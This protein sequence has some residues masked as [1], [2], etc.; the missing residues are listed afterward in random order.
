[1][2][3][4][5]LSTDQSL[6]TES[7]MCD[8]RLTALWLCTSGKKSLSTSS[9]RAFRCGWDSASVGHRPCFQS[10]SS[11][12]TASER[13]NR[14]TL[15]ISGTSFES[16]VI[17]NKYIGS[18]DEI[19]TYPA[20]SNV[21]DTIK[22]IILTSFADASFEIMT[23]V[24]DTAV[25][26]ADVVMA[27]EQTYWDAAEILA[28]KLGAEIFCT[29]TGQFRVQKRPRF[30]DTVPVA[31][32]DEGP[33]GVLVSLGTSVSRDEVYNVVVASHQS[34]DDVTISAVA[35][36]DD[37]ESATYYGG[38]FGKRILVLEPDPLLTTR[39]MCRAK[40]ELTLERKRYPERELDLTFL[41]N[42]ALEPDD[43]VQITMLDGTVENHLIR[44]LNF[45]LSAGTWT[46]ETI[47]TAVADDL[48]VDVPTPGGD[49]DLTLTSLARKTLS[50]Q[51]TLR[52]TLTKKTPVV[53]RCLPVHRLL[54]LR[55]QARHSPRSPQRRSIRST[56]CRTTSV[57]TTS[58]SS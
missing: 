36:D 58:S 43:V 46:A 17:D 52:Q 38:P 50:R 45:P 21:V 27:V 29:P 4:S 49:A 53:L 24:D 28:N 42:P 6:L 37:P 7:P 9:T 2:R 18:T 31:R 5:R 33:D 1:M 23:S 34:S 25:L 13:V 3:D 32:I 48:P 14:G 44:S 19:M 39:D 30:K 41:P 10:G 35:F 47:S 55:L 51:Q 54:L 26:S 22:D 56:S 40:A 8:E 16:Y 15:N 57:V 12:S 11:R 20:G